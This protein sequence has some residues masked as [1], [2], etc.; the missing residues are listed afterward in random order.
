MNGSLKT[1]S[2]GEARERVPK[3]P[4]GATLAGIR[5]TDRRGT[6]LGMLKAPRLPPT[7]DRPIAWSDGGQEAGLIHEQWNV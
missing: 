5:V 7:T 4:L 2:I 3:R 6:D 1:L